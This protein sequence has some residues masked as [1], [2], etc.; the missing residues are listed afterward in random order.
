MRI[1]AVSDEESR[2]YYDCYTPGK[3]EA[4]DLILACGD[5]SR[6]YLEF[7]VTMARCPLLYVH[8]NHDGALL[9]QPP[10]GCTCI[11]GKLV[12]YNGVRILGLGGCLRYRPGDFQYTERQMQ[13]RI[14]RLRR[15]L[16]AGVDLVV[17]HAPPRDLGDLSD[18]AHRGFSSFVRLLDR[19]RPAF[20]LHGHV[21]LRYQPLQSR[22]LHYHGTRI[23]NVSERYELEL[24]DGPIP[25]RDRNQLFRQ[26]GLPLL[27]RRRCL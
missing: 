5:L 12:V 9:H 7:L 19:Y 20:L 13:R 17:T 25:S 3:L 4:F 24:P 15:P 16:C 21:H 1:L 11:D 14:H 6:S 26:T 18:P 8:G 22:E 10:L 23:I 27:S 2:A